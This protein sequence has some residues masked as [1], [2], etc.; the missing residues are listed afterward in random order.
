MVINPDGTT[1]FSGKIDKE[2]NHVSI[3]MEYR[4]KNL[5]DVRTFLLKGDIASEPIFQ[6]L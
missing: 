1:H 3:L 4:S 6:C 5:I 2:I